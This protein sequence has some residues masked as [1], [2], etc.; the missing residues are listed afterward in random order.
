MDKTLTIAFLVLSAI[1]TVGLT[2]RAALHDPLLFT[3]GVAALGLSGCVA[4]LTLLSKD[5]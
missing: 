5:N 2:I 3:V 1:A 4:I